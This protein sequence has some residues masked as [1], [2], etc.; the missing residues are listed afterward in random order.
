MEGR[1]GPHCHQSG[2][3]PDVCAL[4]RV[5]AK[6]LARAAECLIDSLTPGGFW[7][8]KRPKISDLRTPQTLMPEKRTRSADQRQQ[9]QPKDEES[10]KQQQQV[11]VCQDQ[12]FAL[13]QIGEQLG[14]GPMRVARDHRVEPARRRLEKLPAPPREPGG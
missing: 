5:R 4:L 11:V 3:S 1:I 14:R 10:P 9:Y 13:R 2:R 12:R 7:A 8:P 6:K